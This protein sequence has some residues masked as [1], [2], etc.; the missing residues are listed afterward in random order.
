MKALVYQEIIHCI[1]QA[2]PEFD[3]VWII[4][5]IEIYINQQKSPT[6]LSI[7][8]PIKGENNIIAT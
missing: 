7:D 3:Y 4:P 2:S 8:T 1:L 6:I 5:F